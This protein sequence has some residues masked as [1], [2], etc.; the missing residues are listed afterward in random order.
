MAPYEVPS[1]RPARKGK[2][3]RIWLKSD[4][5]RQRRVQWRKT[6]QVRNFRS[7][8]AEKTHEIFSADQNFNES[9]K[10]PA[11]L[12]S[13]FCF[14]TVLRRIIW[15]TLSVFSE[16]QKR[17]WCVKR[18]LHEDSEF[19]TAPATSWHSPAFWHFYWLKASHTLLSMKKHRNRTSEAICWASMRTGLCN[20]SKRVKEAKSCSNLQRMFAPNWDSSNFCRSI[21]WLI[22]WKT[23]IF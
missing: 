5:D 23:A 6:N 2:S 8:S 17:D 22:D 13:D 15:Q 20:L 19:S 11:Q 1:C 3:R 7:C 14:A 9:W 18:V 12:R 10:F 21:D 4:N 16:P